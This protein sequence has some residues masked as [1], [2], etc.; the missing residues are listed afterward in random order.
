MGNEIEDNLVSNWVSNEQKTLLDLATS[1]RVKHTGV[2][3]YKGKPGGAPEIK[4]EVIPAIEFLTGAYRTKEP[5]L[6][7]LAIAAPVSGKALRLA[8]PA[9]KTVAKTTREVYTRWLQA[10]RIA[11]IPDKVISRIAQVAQSMQYDMKGFIKLLRGNKESSKVLGK[12][13]GITKASA[14]GKGV[15]QASRQGMKRPIEQRVIASPERIKRSRREAVKKGWKQRK[16]KE[17]TEY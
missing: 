12:G 11:E 5:N 10:A 1:G 9:F 3:K 4:E 16:N 7:T 6:A 8:M 13:L 14:G 15:S 17:V 2:G